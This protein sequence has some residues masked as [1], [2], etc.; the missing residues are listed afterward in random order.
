MNQ[1]GFRAMKHGTA[2]D[3]KMLDALERHYASALPH[4]LVQAL[5]RLGHS[6]EGYQ[7]S[8]LHHSLQTATRA[9][10]DGA[11]D[12]LVAAALLHDIGDDLA[13]CNHAAL[14]A[15]II[16]P[17]V[18]PE[19]TWIVAHHGTFQ[20]YYY[21]HHLGGNRDAREALRGHAW[22]DAC[23]H[24][25]ETYDQPS[26]DPDYPTRALPHFMPLLERIF[27]QDRK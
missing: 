7:V 26:F 5:E 25:C 14:A 6:L 24:F 23:A 15:E 12:E 10:N 21:A 1:V 8:R 17:Y 18:R 3:Y 4:R 20:M 13:P 22:F 27:G 9:E 16:R 2:D 11:D 19:V